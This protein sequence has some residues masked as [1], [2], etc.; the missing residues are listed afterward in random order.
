MNTLIEH[1][2]W[3]GD[4]DKSC[5]IE[6]IDSTN[7][8]KKVPNY[9][10]QLATIRS[11]LTNCIDI[12]RSPS[13]SFLL[14]L[15]KHCRNDEQEFTVKVLCS[16]EGMAVYTAEVM[17][18][19]VS[20]VDV[21]LKLDLKVPFTII[22]EHCSRLMP[23]PYSIASAV[24]RHPERIR[25]VFSWSPEQPGLTTSMLRDY[26]N[27]S[28]DVPVSFY[29]RQA[30]A[31]RL[32][33]EDFDK[34]LLMIAPGVGVSPFLGMLD[35]CQPLTDENTERLL[36]TSSRY[37]GKDD[38]FLHELGNYSKSEILTET[39]MTHTRSDKEKIHVQELMYNKCKDRIAHL[40]RD[41]ANFKCFICGEGRVMVPQI[42]TSLVKCMSDVWK[43]SNE[44][45][46]SYLR[47]MKSKQYLVI[48]QWF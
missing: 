13:K 41:G 45:A 19:R 47:D 16:K 40:L 15:L 43:I 48:D 23:R 46:A 38:V 28:S 44:E 6:L 9:I 7:K 1:Q 34:S 12:H 21:L 30:T 36:F 31:F 42:E 4:A 25:L 20:I 39:F 32:Q 8:K 27:S 18:K 14:A 3:A 29:F 26:I 17:E 11:I 24:D 22:L 33:K 5:F 35:A 10:P 2:G 37:K